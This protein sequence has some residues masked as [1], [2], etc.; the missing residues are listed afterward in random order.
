[1]KKNR[2]L[3]FSVTSFTLALVTFSLWNCQSVKKTQKQAHK[4]TS[5]E[6]DG[7]LVGQVSKEQLKDFAPWYAENHRY[8]ELNENLIQNF[9]KALKK[10][11]IE[12]FMGTWCPDSHREVPAFFRILETANYPAKKVKLYAVNRK[13]E[14]GLDAEKGKKI[15]HVPTFI[16]HQNGKEVAR[17][18]ESPIHSLEQ[19]IQDIVNGNPQTPHYAD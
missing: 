5:K 9:K 3:R 14:T 15:T 16:F 11:D 10:Y 17:I 13:K 19:D 8:H 12:V 4:F 18:V 6:I 2:F 1:M 7:M